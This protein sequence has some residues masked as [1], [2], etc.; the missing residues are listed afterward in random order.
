MRAA[1]VRRCRPEE[2]FALFSCLAP[3]PGSLDLAGTGP[4]NID[5]ADDILADDIL[6]GEMLDDPDF[7]ASVLDLLAGFPPS[8]YPFP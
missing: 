7:G 8:N 1:P 4:A 6:A 3:T 5:L 2:K